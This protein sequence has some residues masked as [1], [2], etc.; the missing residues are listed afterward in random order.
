MCVGGGDIDYYHDDF[1]LSIQ[2]NS[3]FFLILA[4]VI[5]FVFKLMTTTK[6]L[7]LFC[8]FLL[9]HFLFGSRTSKQKQK[10]IWASF[11]E[12]SPDSIIIKQYACQ[13]TADEDDLIDY[14]LFRFIDVQTTV[15]VL[16]EF[17]F[18]LFNSF[19]GPFSCCIHLYN[20]TKHQKNAEKHENKQNLFEPSKQ[21]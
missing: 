2:L 6:K 8:Q 21:Q 17:F 5:C 7:C 15:C 16:K 18:F 3:V 10:K 19:N 12:K 4:Q 14:R 13:F 20:T 11:K 1:T 9:D